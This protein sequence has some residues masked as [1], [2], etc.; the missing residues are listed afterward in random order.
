MMSS[1][2]KYLESLPD[3]DGDSFLTQVQALFLSDFI[4]K[5]Q[6]PDQEEGDSLNNSPRP[7]DSDEL[8]YDQLISEE[9]PLEEWRDPDPDSGRVLDNISK[10]TGKLSEESDTMVLHMGSVL[11]SEHDYLLWCE[12]IYLFFMYYHVS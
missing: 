3:E 10:T 7:A 1:L 11:S 8:A 9:R 5:Q 6:V 12:I 2:A 4:G